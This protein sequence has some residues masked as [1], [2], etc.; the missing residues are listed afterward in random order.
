MNGCMKA[1]VLYHSHMRKNLSRRSQMTIM[2]HINLYLPHI[3]N[4]HS[5]KNLSFAAINI[6]RIFGI[7]CLLYGF[8]LRN[9]KRWDWFHTQVVGH[10]DQKEIV[11]LTTCPPSLLAGCQHLSLYPRCRNAAVRH[12]VNFENKRPLEIQLP[13]TGSFYILD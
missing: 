8:L 4:R 11:M 9:S 12:I 10:F 5:I 2:T 1:N 7:E 3:K 6:L 13:L